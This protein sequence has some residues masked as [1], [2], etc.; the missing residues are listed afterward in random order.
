MVGL[1]GGGRWGW[2]VGGWGGQ[3]VV[4]KVEDE[5]DRTDINT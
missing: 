4:V 2:V 3:W 1:G 5:H